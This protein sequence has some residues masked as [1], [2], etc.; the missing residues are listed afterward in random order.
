MAVEA[1]G[2]AA[3]GAGGHLRLLNQHGDAAGKVSRAQPGNRTASDVNVAVEG[4]KARDRAED[5]GLSSAVGP[6]QRQPFACRDGKVEVPD[7]RPS[8]VGDRYCRKA[9]VAHRGAPRVDRITTMKKGAPKKAVIT[10]IGS[11]AGATT[12]RAAVSARTRKAAPNST[13]RGTTTR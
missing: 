11:S 5:S 8:F 7:H 6:D 3:G 10:P 9:D 13:E 4:H 2:S 12:V 1:L